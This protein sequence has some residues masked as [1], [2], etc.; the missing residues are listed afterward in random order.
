MLALYRAYIK[1]KPA[2]SITGKYFHWTPHRKRNKGR[3]KHT[4]RRE[5]ETE[6]NG[7]RRA[8]KELH[9]L[10]KNK[11]TWCEFIDW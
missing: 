5:L 6:I 2:G 4:H 3:L 8:W 1:K 9:E 10:A 11:R 7:I